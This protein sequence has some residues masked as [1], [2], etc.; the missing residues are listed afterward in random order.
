MNE[1]SGETGNAMKA[2]RKGVATP[3]LVDCL[4]KLPFP[5]HAPAA[6]AQWRRDEISLTYTFISFFLQVF[7]MHDGCLVQLNYDMLHRPSLQ[8]FMA[9]ASR[10]R[11]ITRLACLVPT[12]WVLH[13][14][15]SSTS[16]RLLE[17][18]L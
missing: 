17:H 5:E 15:L 12:A 2:E 18:D 3:A 4:P 9:Y 11:V 13:T 14:L 10:S 8:R 16:I 6:T 1:D 7:S